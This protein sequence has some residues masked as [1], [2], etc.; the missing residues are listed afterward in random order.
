MGSREPVSESRLTVYFEEPFWV[1]VFERVENGGLSA[2]K[3]TFGAE[4]RDYEVWAFFLRNHH[5]LSFSPALPVPQ[6]QTPDNPKRRQRVARRLVQG[7]GAGTRSQQ[8]LAAQREEHKTE[9]V[10]R[11]REQRET[12]KARRFALK[13]QKRRQ[14]HRGR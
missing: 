1:G 13:Q 7:S 4:P 8:A 3:V 6:R 10:R 2:A 11:G 5:R 14:K 9:R 12:E